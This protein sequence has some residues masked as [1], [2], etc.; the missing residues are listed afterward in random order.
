MGYRGTWLLL[1]SLVTGC[2]TENPEFVPLRASDGASSTGRDDDPLESDGGVDDDDDADDDET[3]DSD[4]DG[5]TGPEQVC[6]DIAPRRFQV[7]VEADCDEPIAI[8]WRCQSLARTRRDEWELRQCCDAAGLDPGAPC[9]NDSFGSRQISF[10]PIESRPELRAATDI[11]VS[12]DLVPH[13]GTCRANW[14]EIA[15]E[16]RILPLFAGSRVRIPDPAPNQALLLVSELAPEDKDSC[17]CEAPDCCALPPGSWR[18]GFVPSALGSGFPGVQLSEGET[19]NAQV[20]DLG[21][22]FIHN[23]VSH[24]GPECDAPLMVDWVFALPVSPR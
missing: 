21:V 7:E 6:S 5:D 18:L 17:A 12:A 15:K 20:G 2:S 8:D 3:T 11:A 9:P 23:Y 19:F 14:I 22:P 24:R 10:G 1:A 13:D 16:A 4:G